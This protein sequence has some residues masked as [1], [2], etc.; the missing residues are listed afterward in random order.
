MLAHAW[1]RADLA[2]LDEKNRAWLS[3]PQTV[4]LGRPRN[5]PPELRSRTR[6]T[7]SYHYNAN[8][9]E[10]HP[11]FRRERYGAASRKVFCE[12]ATKSTLSLAWL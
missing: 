8:K 10:H 5:R 9:P 7:S 1:P 4:D 12:R 3:C 11:V 6:E 2:F